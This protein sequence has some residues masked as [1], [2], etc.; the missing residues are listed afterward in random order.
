MAIKLVVHLGPRMIWVGGE[1][2]GTTD[3][4]S[5]DVVEATPEELIKLREAKEIRL[6]KILG[7][8]GEKKRGR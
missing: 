8:S 3:D 2:L 7:E 4:I 5:L 6:T 1:A